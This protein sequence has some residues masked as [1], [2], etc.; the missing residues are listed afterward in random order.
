MR[1][2]DNDDFMNY[3][4]FQLYGGGTDPNFKPIQ[5]SNTP[6]LNLNPR[7]VA[8]VILM[9]GMCA[10]SDSIG[11]SV[12][13]TNFFASFITSFLC[14]LVF[15]LYVPWS[16][17]NDRI[18]LH[19]SY[20]FTAILIFA[21]IILYVFLNRG[22]FRAP[23]NVILRFFYPLVY[24]FFVALSLL[25]KKP[26]QLTIWFSLLAGSKIMMD[27]LSFFTYSAHASVFQYIQFFIMPIAWIVLFAACTHPGWKKAWIIV[28][29]IISVWTIPG[30]IYSS[31]ASVV[32]SLVNAAWM[33]MLA[34]TMSK[35]TVLIEK[36]R[37]NL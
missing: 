26:K 21:Y 3:V 23:I 16:M 17:K 1:N 32:I 36:N 24:V 12:I 7:S 15:F 25:R 4:G 31:A 20:I 30:L 9:F 10:I 33:I 22:L 5:A 2:Q 37:E 13:R 14:G 11:D 27:A 18:V 28:G 34:Y 35:S 6:H 19:S 8:F 29:I